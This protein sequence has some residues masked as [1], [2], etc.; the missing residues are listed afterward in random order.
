M[1]TTNPFELIISHLDEVQLTVNNI[2][3]KAQK[4]TV[5]PPADPKRLLDLT[6]AA[7]IARK[8]VGTVRHYIHHRKSS[9]H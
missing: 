5:K 7:E 6:E 4:E 1:Q 8:P 2:S 9:C 3:D